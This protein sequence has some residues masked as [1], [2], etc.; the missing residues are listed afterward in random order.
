MID[1]EKVIQAI[2]Y[3]TNSII[4]QGDKCPYWKEGVLNIVCWYK[5]IKDAA[6]LLK[7]DQAELIRQRDTIVELQVVHDLAIY[8]ASD[9]KDIIESAFKDAPEINELI[10]KKLIA[11]KRKVNKW[12]E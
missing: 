9:A 11:E 10:D 7:A 6:E 12:T 4:C 3:C 5:I 2:E 1:R 8:E